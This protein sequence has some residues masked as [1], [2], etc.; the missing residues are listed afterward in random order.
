MASKVG[1]KKLCHNIKDKMK[2]QGRKYNRICYVGTIYAL[3]LYLC[4]STEDEIENTFYIFDGG[5]PEDLYT[6]FLPHAI[7]IKETH[8]THPILRFVRRYTRLRWIFFRYVQWFIL[9]K[10]SK[11]DLLFTQ[12]HLPLA[13]VVCSQDYVL[14]ED[15]PQ[16]FN[17]IWKNRSI[18]EHIVYNRSVKARLLRFLYG[19]GFNGEWGMSKLCRALLVTKY[20]DV[21]YIQHLPQIMVNVKNCWE[22]FSEVKRSYILQKFHVTSEDI[23]KLKQRPIIVFTQPFY[24]ELIDIQQHQ[25]IYDRLLSHYP[26]NKVL[27]KKHPRD[28]FN[29]LSLYADVI[30]FS[31]TIPS[32]LITMLGIQFEKAVTVNSTAVANFNYEIEIDWYGENEEILKFMGHCTMPSNVNICTL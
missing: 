4:H 26:Q 10:I 6:T 32:Q 12:D 31:K 18:D 22:N 19:N 27:I 9:P 7:L 24:P 14:I 15:S 28:M 1:Y 21:A 30:E 20:D 17:Y 29:Y 8:F 2:Y 16:I 23:K 11:M 3:L 13:S 5:F 25:T